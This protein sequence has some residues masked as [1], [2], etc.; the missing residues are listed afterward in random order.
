METLEF[1]L[2]ILLYAVSIVFIVIALTGAHRLIKD[3]KIAKKVE[4]KLNPK[5]KEGG[6]A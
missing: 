6:K 3:K 1:I 5:T 2:K 4:D